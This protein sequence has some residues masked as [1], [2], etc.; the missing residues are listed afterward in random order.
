L[1][2]NFF[3]TIYKRNITWNQAYNDFWGGGFAQPKLYAAFSKDIMS[4]PYYVPHTQQGKA[5][6]VYQAQRYEDFPTLLL[7]EEF[8]ATMGYTDFNYV[9]VL[10]YAGEGSHISAH[11][12]REQID[13]YETAQE[14][15]ATFVFGSPRFVGNKQNSVIIYLSAD[16]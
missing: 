8:L 10:M 3:S 14:V 1:E 5:T 7:L 16:R 6:L 11:R 12:D 4:L 9:T 15:I 2:T 13:G